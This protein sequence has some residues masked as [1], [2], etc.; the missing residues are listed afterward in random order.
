KM[1]Q[2]E[3]I[4][5]S[6]VTN[7][8]LGSD[9][10]IA[11]FGPQKGVALEEIGYFEKGMQQFA[12]VAARSTGRNMAVEPGSGPAGGIGL[13]LQTILPVSFRSGLQMIAELAE[14]EEQMAGADLILTGEG[15]VDRQ[16]LFGKVPVGIGRLAK[17]RKVP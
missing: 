8:L 11:V 13:L 6:D 7:P 16:S 9:G 14:M 1:K 3:I 4:I 15:Q 10:A 5:A 2:A 12:E 17:E